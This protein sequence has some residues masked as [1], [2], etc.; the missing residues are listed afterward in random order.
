MVSPSFIGRSA[1]LVVCFV[2]LRFGSASRVSDGQQN[3][4]FGRRCHARESGNFHYQIRYE[5]GSQQAIGLVWNASSSPM[6]AVHE[7]MTWMVSLSDEEPRSVEWHLAPATEG[8]PVTAPVALAISSF[9]RLQR[10][11][12]PDTLEV[13]L[14]E[15]GG[16][17]SSAASFEGGIY[18]PE[19]LVRPELMD[20]ETPEDG[21]A[22]DVHGRLSAGDGARAAAGGVVHTGARVGMIA[23]AIAGTAVVGAVGA[24]SSALTLST[25]AGDIAFTLLAGSGGLVSG[26]LAGRVAGA[27]VSLP[28]AAV[29]SAMAW[30]RG[31]R[32]LRPFV[33]SE[34]MFDTLKCHG[35]FADCGGD[36]FV[37][38]GASC[39]GA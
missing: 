21:R 33:A 15:G 19:H 25:L 18:L 30:V 17:A 22:L 4:W 16:A 35:A 34:Q 23:G 24:V 3:E 20:A 9:R 10:P 12:L 7:N 13:V 8:G 31:N 28:G 37:L 5:D 1:W 2:Y 26:G 6:I 39:P 27:V 14:G 11:N 32:E 36:A 38:Q 29:S